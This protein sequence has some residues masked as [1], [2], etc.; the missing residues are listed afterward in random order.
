MTCSACCNFEPIRIDCLSDRNVA[1]ASLAAGITLLV[2]VMLGSTGAIALNTRLSA[3]MIALGSGLTFLGTLKLGTSIDTA[4][5]K[6]TIII[7]QLIGILAVTL[8]SLGLSG[9]LPFL[10]GGVGAFLTGSGAILL[11]AN[12]TNYYCGFPYKVLN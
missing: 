4:D 3:G 8:G 7:L 2:I 12:Y 5:R 1:I 10:R 6:A 9:H 11:L